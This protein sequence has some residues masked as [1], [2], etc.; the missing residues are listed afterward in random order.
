MKIIS[1]VGPTA[2]GKTSFVLDLSEKILENK[3]YAG[4][5]L[6]SADSRQVYQGL[7]IISGADVPSNFSLNTDQKLIYPFYTKNKINLHGVSIVSPDK[8][9]SVIHFQDLAWEIIK[10]AKKKNRLV[11]VIGGTGLYHDQLLNLDTSL[12]IKPNDKVRQKAERMKLE[13]LQNWAEKVNP[14]RLVKM[15][16]S[17]KNNPRRLIRVIE[18]GLKKSKVNISDSSA[19][20]FEQIYIG[21]NQDLEKIAEKIKKRVFGRFSDQA[22][23]EIKQLQEKYNDWSLPAF[24]ALG[25]SEVGQYLN[26]FFSKEECL[27]L[28]SLHEFQYAKRQLTWWRNRNVVWFKI[29][30]FEWKQEAFA[31]ILNLC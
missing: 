2:V 8:E 31:Y 18:I 6:I 25:V 27:A 23:N 28:W 14:A 26:D 3:A 12:R 1:V 29:D 9:W 11:I 15:N 13:D 10:L 4:I 17:D 30:E 19:Q 7:E 5:D 20:E 16:N 24:S 22:I 21:L